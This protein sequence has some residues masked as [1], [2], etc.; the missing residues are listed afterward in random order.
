MTDQRSITTTFLRCTR[1]A[2]PVCGLSSIF[3]RP[4]RIRHHCRSCYALFK[5][6]EGFFVGAVAVNLVTTEIVVLAVYLIWLFSVS[7]RYEAMITVLLLT[8]LLFPA[9]FYHHSWGLWLSFDY[10]IE[11]LP[12]Y[13]D[14]DPE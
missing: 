8:A 7:G 11:S 3:E 12:K 6:E 13:V 10:L 5:R 14:E 1:L 2:C 4:F 9:L